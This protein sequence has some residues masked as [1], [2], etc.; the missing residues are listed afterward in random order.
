MTTIRRAARNDLPALERLLRDSFDASYALFLPGQYVR[1][2]R[3]SDEPS[4]TLRQL[5]GSMGVALSGTTPVGFVACQN[6]TVAELWVSP[7]YK[8]RG[9]GTALLQWAEDWLREQGFSTAKLN[10]YER[11]TSGLAFYRKNGY[12]VTDRFP[13]RRIAGGP[14]TVFTLSK[15]LDGRRG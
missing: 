3:T 1:S 15:A 4:R 12:A 11:N 10:C 5:M 14:V 9:V 8:R 7:K 2:W 6:D 13:S